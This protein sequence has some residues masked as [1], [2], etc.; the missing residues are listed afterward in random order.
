MTDPVAE[1]VAYSYAPVQDAILSFPGD[2][3]AATILPNDSA[4]R[5]KFDSFSADIPKITPRGTL[6]GDTS[7]VTYDNAADP[8]CWWTKTLC[9]TPK[10]S[11]LKAD[12]VS[13]PEPR[14][15]GY[16]FDDGPS[17]EHNCFY[18]Y[19]AQ[20]QQKA[21]MFFIGSNVLGFPLEAQRAV[22]DGHEI[23]VHTW[24]HPSMTA[25]TNEGAFAELWY[26]MQIIKLVTN[27]TPTCWRPPRGDVDDRIRY[28]A[29]QLGLETIM[30]GFDA[31]DWQAN[32]TG[33]VTPADVQSKYDDL[34][35]KAGQGAFDSV[36]AI[37][38][39]HELNNYTMQ[40]AIDNYP[41]LVKAFDHI[42]PVGVAQN[43]THPYQETTYTQPDFSAYIAN[44]T[45]VASTTSS[46][47]STNS[48][49]GSQTTGTG[50]AAALRVPVLALALALA[51]AAWL[52]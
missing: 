10:L 38:L 34:M 51:G 49:L 47:S 31:F 43:K 12:I 28:I 3:T 44:R 25:A 41:K 35:A 36:G 1:C 6:T 37:I 46:N 45:R 30:W 40:T 20:Q 24:S 19:L 16:G 29:E 4:A 52:R 27:I 26:T 17:C 48:S 14:T 15:L 21:T 5:T 8:D 18:D 42:V 13:V 9:T 2:W 33:P 7:K 22:T 23:C 32:V 50:A 39:T 11:G